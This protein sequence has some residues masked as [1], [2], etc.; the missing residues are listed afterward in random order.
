MQKSLK[1]V[2]AVHF[3]LF[4]IL[5]PQLV[6][7]GE[8]QGSGGFAVSADQEDR[9]F[10]E[11]EK[12]LKIIESSDRASALPRVEAA[13][14]DVM[15]KFPGSKA[16]QESYWRLLSLYVNDYNPPQYEEAEDLYADFVTTYPESPYRNLL[17]ETLTGGY[18]SNAQWEKLLSFYTPVIRRFIETGSLQSSEA[19]FMYS[20][21]KLNLRDFSEAGKGY[22]IIISLFPD[23][24]DSMKARQRLKQLE[25]IKGQN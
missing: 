15:N 20:E 2:A 22:R 10:E 25:M 12:V 24:K 19:M 21:A 9:A 8:I 11:F 16:A 13:Y 23:S 18:Y 1:K 17:E 7:S 5:L 3:F 6:C 4:L 14:R